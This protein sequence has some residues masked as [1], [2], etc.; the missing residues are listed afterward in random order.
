[1][2]PDLE[3]LIEAAIADGVITPKERSILHKKAEK[4]GEDLDELDMLLDGMLHIRQ[5]A[6]KTT[7]TPTP[8]TPI[9]KTLTAIICP[10]CGSNE[11]Q[12]IGSDKFDCNHCQTKSFFPVA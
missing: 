1:M 6:E 7:P 5:K 2:H 11:I 9:N 10:A 4:L 3:R 12:E 8:N